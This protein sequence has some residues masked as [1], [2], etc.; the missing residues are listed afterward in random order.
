VTHS[1]ILEAR[2]TTFKELREEFVKAAE[3]VGL[4][5]IRRNFVKEFLNISEEERP[6]DRPEFDRIFTSSDLSDIHVHP[7]D[8]K[9]I[10]VSKKGR[11]IYIK[12]SDG[13]STFPPLGD[14]KR[15]AQ[16]GLLA[17]VD[18]LDSWA[19]AIRKNEHGSF[20]IVKGQNV[21]SIEVDMGIGVITVLD[22]SQKEEV[23]EPSSD[24]SVLPNIQS[25]GCFEEISTLFTMVDK[26]TDVLNPE[27]LVLSIAIFRTLLTL[28]EPSSREGSYLKTNLTSFLNEW[29]DKPE[30]LPAALIYVEAIDQYGSRNLDTDARWIVATM[31]RICHFIE[32]HE[33]S[34]KKPFTETPKV[35]EDKTSHSLTAGIEK[36]NHLMEERNAIIESLAFSRIGKGESTVFGKSIADRMMKLFVPGEDVYSALLHYH[37]RATTYARSSGIESQLLKDLETILYAGMPKNYNSFNDKVDKEILHMFNASHES[38][39]SR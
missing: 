38:Q 23:K 39:R 36:A 21:S 19:I 17:A 8:R 10:D 9:N 34:Q 6:S 1:K 18:L 20:K 30:T 13:E 22:S 29:D 3:L 31:R 12:L 28:I 7:S 5:I 24:R 14:Y 4:T 11:K 26:L 27:K 35:S 16:Y 15:S 37:S 2:F 25:S 33:A 32:E